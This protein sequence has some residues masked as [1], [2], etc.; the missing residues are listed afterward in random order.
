MTKWKGIAASYAPNVAELFSCASRQSAVAFLA[1]ALVANL[2]AGTASAA[3]RYWDVNQTAAG[4]GGTGIWNLTNLF[5]SP[6]SSDVLGPYNQPWDNGA[7][8]RAIFAGTA[9]TVTLGSAITVNALTFNTNGYT[10]AGTGANTLTLGGVTPTVTVTTGTSTIGAVIAGSAGLTKTGGGT[11]F[12]TGANT[13][14]GGITLNGGTL[15][16][17]DNAAFGAAGNTITTTANATL[18]VDSGAANRTVSIAGGTTLTVSGTGVGS[19]L[20]SGAGNLIALPGVTLSNDNSDFTGTVQLNG[21]SQGVAN[22]AFTSVRNV[23]QASSLGAGGTITFTGGSQFSDNITYIG[24]GD[25]SNRDWVMA[26]PTL[27]RFNNSGTGALTLT[28]NFNLAQATQFNAGTADFNLLGVLSGA[29]SGVT[30]TASAGRNVTLGGAN[31]FAGTVSLNGGGTI[32]ATVL[33]GSG[34]ASSLGQGSSIAI[35]DATLRYAGSAIS[36]DRTWLLSNNTTLQNDGTGGLTLTGAI[37]FDPVASIDTLNLAGSYAGVNTIASDISDSGRIVMNGAGI[38]VL[39]GNNSYTGTTAVENGTLRAGSA[40]AFNQQNSLTVNGGTFDLGGYGYSFTRLDGTGGTVELGSG[41][42]VA[43]VATG[44]S[45]SFAGR[46]QGSGG[47]TKR[48]GGTQTLTGSST[49]TGDTNIEGGT[50][51]LDFSKPESA[52]DD[53]ISSGSTLNMAGGTLQITGA[54]GEANS[55]GFDGLYIS[56]G[57]NRITAT[58]GASGGTMTVSFGDVARI[59]GQ[60]DF[61]IGSGVTMSVAPGTALGGWATVNGSDYADVDAS[62]NIIAFTDYD[63]EDDAG[64]WGDG[65]IVT[66]SGGAANTPFFGMVSEASGDNVVQLGGLR[67]TVARASTVNVGENQTLGVDGTIIVAASVSN[68]SQSIAQGSVRGAAGGVLGIQQNS[69]GSFAIN[70]TIVDNGGATGLT[71]GGTGTGSVVLG[72][73]ANTYTGAT[74]VTRGKL[75]VATL[76]NGGVDSSIGASSAGSSNL[77]LEGGTLSYTGGSVST[78]RGFTVMRSGAITGGTIE[79]TQASANVA[80]GGEVVS[81]D[82]A[83]LT[84]TGAG[85]LTLTNANSS[86]TGAT[87]VSGGGT[88]SVTTL[89]NGGSNSSIGASSSDS[90]NLFIEGG[91]TFQYTGGSVTSDR[92]FTLNGI[93]GGI[94]DVTNAGTELA[95]GGTMAGLGGAPLTKAGVGTLILSGMNTYRGQIRVDAGT[96]RA[97]STQAFGAVN[98]VVLADTAGATLDLDGF[99]N[100]VAGLSGGGTNGGNVLL[101]DAILTMGGS[102]AS[103]SGAISGTGGLVK[104]NSSTQTMVGCGSSYTGST[105]IRAGVLSVDCIRNGGQTSGVGASA[106]A[107]ANLVLTTNGTLQYTGGTVTTDRGFHLPSGWGGIDVVEATTTLDFTGNVTNLANGSL[108]KDGAGTL[109]LSGTNSYAGTL[110]RAGTLVAG[111]TQAFG[112]GAMTIYGGAT[113]DLANNSNAVGFL[114]DENDVTGGTV[115]LGSADLTITSGGARF[116]GT[117]HGTGGLIKIGGGTQGLGGCANTYSGAT[118]IGGGWLEVTCLADGGQAS[119]IGTSSSDA[120]NLVIGGPANG[121]LNYIGAGDTTDRRFTLGASAGYIRSNGTGAVIFENSAAVTY[122]G[123]GARQLRLGGSNTG[124]NILAAQI[125]NNGASAVNLVKDDAGTWRLTNT[126]SSYTG[127]TTINGSGGVLEVT[128]LANGGENSSI[129][130]S[131]AAA[132]N[133]VIGTNGT[134]RYVG[135]GVSTNR[136]FTLGTGTTIIESSGTGAV[137]FTDSGGLMGF[138]GTGARTFTLGGTYAGDNIMGVTIRDQSG[139]AQ[140]SLAKNDAGTW[141]LTANNTYTGNTVINDGKLIIGNGGTTGNVGT[142]EV[143]LAFSTGTLGFNRGDTFNFA[144]KISGPGIIEQMGE[145]TTVL[146][147]VN[148]A[149]ITKI[150]EGALQI[151]G[152]LTTDTIAFDD[153]E[154]T[155]LTVNGTLHGSGVPAAITGDGSSNI[156]NVNAGGTLAATGDLGGGSDTIN[157]SGT[158]DTGAG[159]LN[160]GLGNDTL[161]L[162]DGAVLSGGGIAGGTGGESGAGDILRVVTTAGVTLAGGSVTG[163]ETLDK[164]GTGTLTLTGAHSYTSGTTIAAG[165]LQVGNGATAGMLATPT[166]A[167]NGVLAFNL[168][169]NYTFAGAISGSGGV[170]KLGTGITTLTGINSYTGATNVNAGTLLIDGDQS[171]ATG[172]TSVASGATLGGRGTI[173][174]SVSVADGGTL[175]PGAAGNVPG[176]LTINGDLALNDG[177]ILAVNFGQAGVVGGPYNDLITVGGDLA[178]DGT[179]NVTETPGG[180]FGPGVYRIFSYGGVLTNNGLD[181][182]SPDYFVQTSVASQVNLV[183]SSGLALSFWDG[184]TGPHS[185]ELVNGGSGTWRAAGDQNWTDSTGLFAAPFANAS[186]AIFQGAAG[187]VSVDNGNGQVQA[188]GMQFAANGYRIQ[189]DGIE[190]VDDNTQPGLQ[191]IIRVGDGT[192]AGAGYVATIASALSGATQLVKTD[193]G[194]LVLSGT[195]SYTTGTAI[196]GGTLQISSD[197]NLGAAPGALSLD[198]GTLRNTA[199][200]VSSRSVTLNAGG[201]GFDTLDRLTLNGVVGGAGTLAKTGAGTLVLTATNTYQGGT[202]I[203]GGAVEVAANANLGNAAGGLTLDGGTLHSTATF[204]A[205]R[206]V[207]LNAGGGAFDTDGFTAL[208]LSNTIGGTGALRKAGAGTLVLAGNTIYGGGTTISSG[209][210]QLGA[211]GASGSITGDV[212]NDGTL[213]FN[214]SDSYSF[215]GLISGGGSLEQIGGGVTILTADNSYTGDTVVRE[216]SLLVNGDQSA[217]NGATTVED[218]GV[219]GGTGTIGGDV[220]ILDGGSFNPG[221]VGIVPGTL[222]INGNLSLA[223][224]STLNYNFGQA[225]VVGGAYNDLTVVHGDL[226]LDGTINVAETPGGNFGPGI[227]RVISYD[228][229]LTNL[230]LTESSPD[231]VVQTSVAGQVNL[232]DISAMTLNF[233]DGDAG[234]KG[235]DFVDGGSGTWRA[236][237]D[238]NW[239]DENGNINAAFSNGSFAIFAGTAGQVDVDN[240]NGQVQVSGLQFASNGYLIQ[241]QAITL[242]GTQAIV[243]VGDGTAQ[244]SAYVA[245]IDAMLQ[246]GAQLVKRDLGTLVLTGDNTYTGGTF[247]QEGTLQFS[248]DANLGDAAGGIT[249]DGGTLQNTVA[250]ASARGIT[251]NAAGGTFLADADLTLSGTMGGVGGFTKSGSANLI[252][253]G[254][255]AYAGPTT[256]AGGG[257][258]VDGDQSAAAGPI[259]VQSG[260]TLGGSGTIGGDVIIADGATLSPGAAD[261]MP[262]TLAIAGNLTLSAGSTLNYTFGEANVAGGTLNDLTTVGGDIVLDGTLDVSVAPGGTFG[263]GIYRVFTYSGTLTDNGLSVGAIPSADYFVQTAIANQVNLVN[264]A[265][266]T[267]NY[268]DGGA[269]PKFNGDIDGGDGIW[270][271]SA[272][273]DNWADATGIVNAAF[274]DGAFAI[275]AGRSGTVTVDNSLGQVSAAGMQ[276][277]TDGYVIQGDRIDL[278]GAAATIRV[279]DGTSAGAAMTATIAAELAGSAQ[280]VKTEAGTLVLTGSNGYA[281]GTAING[282]TLQVSTDVNLGAAT[283]GLSFNGGTL[284]T[285]GSFE[286]GRA[287]SF[288]G[289]GTVL[290]DAGTTLTSTGALSGSGSFT[291]SGAGAL[292]LSADSSGFTGTTSVN[293]GTLAV[294]GRLCGDV[295]V[296]DGGRLQGTGTVC[297]TNNFTG[298]TVAPGNSIGTLTVDG[299]YAGNG[300]TLEIE[301]E[302]GGDASPADKLVVTGN[303]SGT[304]SVKVINA[305]GGGAQTSNG[306]KIVDVGGTSAGTFSLAGDYLFQGEQAVVGGAYAYRLYK[307]GVTTP[308]DGD[309]YLRSSLINPDDPDPQP[310]YAPGVPLYEAY[311]SVLQDVNELGTLQQRVGNRSWG[312]GAAPQGTDA[313]GRQSVESNAIWAR[314]EAAHAQLEP[315]AS[316]TVSDY[317]T[318]VWKLQAGIDGLLHE[319]EAGVLIGGVTAHLGTVSADILSVYGTGSISSTGFGIGGTLTWYGESG[320][321]ADAQAQLTWYD[322]DITSATL[323]TRLAEGNGGFGHA[324]GIEAGQ[325]IAI[326]GNWSLTPQGQLAYS[327]VSFDDFTDRY[328]AAVSLGDSDRLTGRLGLSADY[329]EKWIDAAGMAS[330]AHLYGI[331][332]LYYDFLGRS[333]VDV[334][335]VALS[336]R[337]QALWGG[338]GLGGSLSWADGYYTVYGE[339]FARTSLEDFGDSNAVGAKL[340]FSVKW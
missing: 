247:I 324:L 174:G 33:A 9:G 249:L 193:L 253:Q 197:A 199:A 12:L 202:V 46:I 218:G 263:P 278:D 215:A 104:D 234:P 67:Y 147:A 203:N 31:T 192:S 331:G 319:S 300:G 50:L 307:G 6:S 220:A 230:G 58:A 238:D 207:T 80:F 51:A 13:F 287:L 28:G 286:S 132:A 183:N 269:G 186:F 285:T 232:V 111:S 140:T 170:N 15:R 335:G 59:G 290:V 65:D 21:Q 160:L 260:A 154:A 45:S 79:V 259:S 246:G 223:A 96:L 336:S 158:V 133:L 306:I 242:D 239:T 112:T 128:K 32:N 296:R 166:V 123:T 75:S 108:L 37:A 250:Q 38:W 48:G 211:G 2:A 294:N 101:G 30:F 122:E 56:G 310:L 120:G 292:R 171:G 87:V 34:V 54:T 281:G 256:V 157:V 72:N 304:T 228:G 295:N 16:A 177:S 265:G 191:S 129:G 121:G 168:S 116:Y 305:G 118:I 301:A 175:S 312:P 7:L 153:D 332:N 141:I 98:L 255:N 125:G 20:F 180:T 313:S 299:N 328:G 316:T 208:T 270:Q 144:G 172:L 222:T 84:K 187:T 237:G 85:T 91:S 135:S 131:T 337:N 148:T 275:F 41:I 61:G 163:F 83:G 127:A 103:Y 40:S 188:V 271:S 236:A 53:I 27:R 52:T 42:L 77:V 155:T 233:W 24:T 173:G 184:E 254:D 159:V 317:E 288:V 330:R 43:N 298:G 1:A 106:A 5:W 73:A 22:I 235:D 323:G 161:L 17:N 63:L 105:T 274:A 240:T 314:I 164:Q 277:A 229:L 66:D 216:G 194:T 119:S 196:N 156:I 167:N 210:L 110:L 318:T 226:V 92:G 95:L 4:S 268:W 212:A 117:I 252:L 94:I 139:T 136:L 266:L 204:I 248:S 198:G 114:D 195:N 130:A 309:W 78:N 76:A 93:A 334:S 251:L 302:L 89:A 322:S 241:G 185:N 276:F 258:Y 100:R 126:T 124:T 283:G 142:G 19:A 11:L 26:G 200:V 102:N 282:G 115:L 329:E 339:A 264:T 262:G 74:W 49:Y 325:K 88:L 149:G 64:T 244:G 23:G 257:L 8:D 326:G 25:S 338:L 303:T 35:N 90:A 205:G 182:A 261:G 14:S 333:D 82:G 315:A 178:L 146:T 18:T 181:V 68:T 227:Y 150:T 81:P 284:R 217:A 206:N 340:G 55:Q 231:H 311:A 214:R 201:G 273:N 137:N 70:S 44:V 224:N 113:V 145:G 321:Y 134:L 289:A 162:N 3:D 308:A 165:T 267:M 99:D 179:L 62:N 169:S 297:D 47:F 36:T 213:A 86:Y 10:L 176:E 221:D 152:D 109:K 272:G 138:S 190:L 57:S 280:L 320:F 97:G 107:A 219:I 327:S 29:G 243:R 189:G 293:G 143:I 71:V 279:G 225:G 291:K 60:V 151:D 39:S 69:T 209:T 245:T